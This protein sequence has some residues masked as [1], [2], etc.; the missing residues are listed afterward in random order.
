MW[1][2]P[3]A[4]TFPSPREAEAPKL[5]KVVPL[6]IAILFA[7]PGCGRRAG[8][9]TS[10]TQ[11]AD[12]SLWDEGPR[13]SEEPVDTVLASRGERLFKTKTCST[14]HAFGMRITGPDLQGVTRRRTSAWIQRQILH[15]GLM[16]KNDPI[17]HGLLGKYAVQMPNLPLTPEE[18]RAL[19]EFLKRKDR[20]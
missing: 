1:D 18:A 3:S 20:E 7:L 16:T 12:H 11:V 14:C 13:A 2:T 17:A 19:L 9:G 6:A 5:P 15:P 8:E 10:T 4:P